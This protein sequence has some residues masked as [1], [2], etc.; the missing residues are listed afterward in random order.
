MRRCRLVFVVVLC[1]SVPGLKSAAQETPLD[2]ARS[3]YEKGDYHTAIEILK[4]ASAKE[5][6]NGEIQLLLTKSYLEAKQYDEAVRSGEKAVAINPKSSLYHQWL[7][8]A[9]GQKADHVSMF[10]A[11]PLAR[12]TQKEFETAVQ[13]DE[14]NFDVTQ[15]LI[16]YDCTAPSIV[17]GGEDKAQPLIQ[18]LMSQDP[19]E[20]HFGAGVCKAIKKD[21]AGADVEYSKALE[22]KPKSADRIYDI[23]DYFLQRGQGE[24]LLEVAS[25]GEAFA[26]RDP[27]GKYYRAVG[28][29]LKGENHP[30]T[31]KLLREYLQEAPLRST[32]PPPWYVHYWLGRLYESRKDLGKAKV[33]YQEALKLNPKSRRTQEAVKHLGGQ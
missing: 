3:A 19:A 17:G 7:G 31:E 30:D 21:L 26:P 25:T 15:D 28:W 4:A 23:G 33:E 5:P 27:R 32:Y 10:S 14:R 2:V 16:E 13:L 12:K 20:G 6:A 22:N 24:K 8:D 18:K 1:L 9:Y 29:I 11:Y